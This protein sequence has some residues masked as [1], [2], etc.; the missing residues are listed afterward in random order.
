VEEVTG[1]V[2][3]AAG[4][5]DP[6]AQALRASTIITMTAMTADISFFIVSLLEPF[7][8]RIPSL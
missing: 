2:T 5:I 6:P 3:V 1:T 8:C 4:L 7:S